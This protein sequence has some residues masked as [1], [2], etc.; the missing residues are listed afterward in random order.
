LE[1]I[2]MNPI[3]M[4]MVAKAKQAE[5][6]QETRKQRVYASKNISDRSKSLQILAFGL[7]TTG[8]IKRL[9]M[10]AIGNV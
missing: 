1:V 9:V 4:D 10:W 5:M 3:M 2:E 8:V 7:V 6:I